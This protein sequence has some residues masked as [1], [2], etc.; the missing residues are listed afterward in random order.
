MLKYQL[1]RLVAPLCAATLLYAGRFTEGVLSPLIPATALLICGIVLSLSLIDWENAHGNITCYSVVPGL[2]LA[3]TG[4]AA[5]VYG[6][7]YWLMSAHAAGVLLSIF[8]GVSSIATLVAGNAAY[9]RRISI[10]SPASPE[11]T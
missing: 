7:T 11:G 4:M 9:R 2:S 3:L 1:K 8:V 6:L 10:D 5:C